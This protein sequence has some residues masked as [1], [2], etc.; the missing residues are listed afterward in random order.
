MFYA[1]KLIG[2]MIV[3]PGLLCV[4]T[5]VF[6]FVLFRAKKQKIL[7]AAML[8]LSISIWFMSTSVGSSIITGSLEM[9]YLNSLPD[10]KDP[11][12]FLILS[13][14]S[15]CDREGAAVI[16]GVYSLERIYSAVTA[17]DSTKD[18]LIFSGGNVYGY[19][20]R[21]EAEIMGDCARNMGWKGKILLEISSRTTAENMI[22]TK[23]MLSDKNFK[24][25]VI[26]TNAFHIP[27]SMLRA[28]SVFT[29]KNLFSL[30]SGLATSSIFRGIPDLF[31]DAHNFSL[32]CL[33]IKEWI[34][35]LAFKIIG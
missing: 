22:Y 6:S 21:T 11:V 29:G 30:S 23:R 32:S 10:T 24:D 2:S 15:N 17:A 34:G 20:Q 5:A 33:G 31:P 13:G 12:A 1:Y 14:G 3:P 4:I 8:M 9:R 16:P 18:V 35:I 7:S 26:V 25:I 27:R 19:D 28:H